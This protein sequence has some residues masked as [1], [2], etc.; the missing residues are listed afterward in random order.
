MSLYPRIL[1]IVDAGPQ[2]GGGHVMRSLTLA[3]ALAERGAPCAFLNAPGV[4]AMLSAFAPDMPRIDADLGDAQ[5]LLEATDEAAFDAVVFDHYGLTAAD[6]RQIGRG[7]PALTI[8]DLADR[9]LAADI[10]VDS[11]PQRRAEDYQGLIPPGARLL[12]GPGYAPVRPEFAALRGQAL[13]RTPGPVKRVLVAMGLTDVGGVTGEVLDRLR[14]R[15]GDAAI[16]I[17][18]GD[19]APSRGGLERLARRDTRLRLHVDTPHM[20]ELMAAADFAVGAAGSSSWERCT[21]ALPSLL[22]ILADNQRP[23]A[24]ALG[25]MGAALVVD[26]KTLDF[27]ETFDRAVQRLLSDPSTRARLSA[28]SAEVCDGLGATRTADAFLELIA[29]RDSTPRAQDDFS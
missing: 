23:A 26:P 5:A 4:A 14:P 18:L 15:V 3:R 25:A 11:G 10:V 7:R 27:D 24:T 16:D 19:S 12:L 17:V 20:A 2:V 28:K 8:D 29:A 13:A 9:P 1:F 22:V 21:L 6:H